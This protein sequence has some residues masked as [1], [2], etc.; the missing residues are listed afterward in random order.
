MKR[1][2]CI[3]Q[4]LL[5]FTAVAGQ[6]GSIS[7][8]ILNGETGE[9]IGN[10]SVF[11]TN[12]SKGTTSNST[13]DFMLENLPEGTHDLVVS[14]IG[15][16]TQPYTYSSGQLPLRLKIL[17]KPKAVELETIVVEP[18][19][20]DGWTTWGK[21]FLD[22][23]IGVSA[24]AA[25]CSIENYQVIRFRN[26]KKNNE[27]TAVAAEPLIIVNRALGYRIKYQLEGFSFN[28]NTHVLL[29]FG[30][31]LFAELNK[32]GP[33]KRQLQNRDEAFN[34]SVTSFIM[35]LYANRLSDDGFEVKRLVKT[36]NIERARVQHIY[37]AR[38]SQ[39]KPYKDSSVYY[40]HILKQPAM[41]ET[42]GQ[43]LLTADSIVQP[44]DERRKSLQFKDYLY[45]TYK[46]A[47]EDPAYLQFTHE[48][49]KPFYQ[50]SVI[51]LVNERAVTIDAR[52]NY[53]MPQDF[54]SYGY[55]GWNEKICNML[56]LEYKTATQ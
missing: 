8:K 24:N 46:K 5:L 29:Y 12:T 17:L 36:P 16:E 31:S 9:A 18:F 30:Y 13:G 38:L 26:S 41:F 43:G 45:I 19:E 21:F 49:R 20:K 33:R 47:N 6:S 39:Q 14:C 7:G 3:V 54:M 55:W 52:G 28:F 25:Q 11:I 35:S 34:G 15:Y 23:F 51:F 40:E 32:N 1:L 27:L 53:F 56:P 50:H 48:N 37:R 44:I 42:Y 22:N 2:L 10:A 4:V